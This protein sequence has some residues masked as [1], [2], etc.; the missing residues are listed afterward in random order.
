MTDLHAVTD[1]Q[2]DVLDASHAAPVVVDFWAPWCGPCRVLGP[3]L[4]RLAAD[5]GGRWTLAKVNTDEAPELMQ[6]YGIRGI[7]AVKLFVDGD[8]AAE[9]TGALPEAAVRQWLDEHLPSPGR[10]RLEA[11]QRAFEAG[12]LAT[13]RTE[14]ETALT[15]TE[16]ETA[17]W[18]AD[19]QVLL[20]RLGVF[21]APDRARDLV[22]GLHTTEAE[23][24]RTLA[25]VLARAPEAL[26]EGA[27]R[28]R[29][30]DALAALRGGD[31]DAAIEA[32]LDVIRADRYYDDDGARKAVVALFQTLG[33]GHAVTKRHRPAFN[34]S[35]Y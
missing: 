16:A 25:D 32:Y 18:A 6:A 19:A 27:G 11:A 17:A 23:A 10:A 15:S 31:L 7:P 33:E 29:T 5:A 14:A 21:D 12:D 34:M 20:A 8:V 1:F 28:A 13:A 30:A 22:D 35:L 24:V 3:T 26:P 2:A 4:D 9:F